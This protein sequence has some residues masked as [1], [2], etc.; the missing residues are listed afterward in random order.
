ME[1]NK[2]ISVDIHGIKDGQTTEKINGKNP[3][4]KGQ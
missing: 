4:C 3:P 1:G 2:K